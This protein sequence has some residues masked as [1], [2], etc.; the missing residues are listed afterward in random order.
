[1]LKAISVLLCFRSFFSSLGVIPERRDR[2]VEVKKIA[3]RN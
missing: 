2:A 1:M 3:G